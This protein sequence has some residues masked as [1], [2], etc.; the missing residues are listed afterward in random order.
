MWLYW[1][2]SMPWIKPPQIANHNKFPKI[3]G[4]DCHLLCV[5]HDNYFSFKEHS[6]IYEFL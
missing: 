5:I 3:Y 6:F 2:I 1:Y 4:E